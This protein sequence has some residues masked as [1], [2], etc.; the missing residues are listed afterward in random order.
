MGGRE[1]DRRAMEGDEGEEKGEKDKGDRRNGE[2]SVPVNYLSA[3]IK[4]AL[5]QSIL[6]SKLQ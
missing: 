1:K 5:S 3:Q 4:I 2:V 6:V